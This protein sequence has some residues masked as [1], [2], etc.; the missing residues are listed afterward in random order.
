MFQWCF[1]GDGGGGGVVVWLVWCIWVVG[2][3]ELVIQ[4]EFGC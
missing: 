2:S 1:R 3:M 4:C